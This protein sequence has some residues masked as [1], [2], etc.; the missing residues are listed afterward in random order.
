MD[1]MRGPA[2]AEP[3]ASSDD[4]AADGDPAE[5][6]SGSDST[7]ATWGDPEDRDELDPTPG[8]DMFYCIWWRL[9]EKQEWWRLRDVD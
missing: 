5:A 9:R 2:P 8:Q 3:P 1:R 6:P 7:R 4:P